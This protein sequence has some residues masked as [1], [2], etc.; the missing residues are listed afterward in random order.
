ME[1][2]FT[3]LIITLAAICGFALIRLFFINI[4]KVSYYETKFELEGQDVERVKKIGFF[5]L[6]K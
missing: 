1:I 3:D 4:Y 2:T 5:G 6:F